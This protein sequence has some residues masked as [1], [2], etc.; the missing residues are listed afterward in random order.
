MDCVSPP[1][2][3]LPRPAQLRLTALRKIDHILP[4]VQTLPAGSTE[5]FGK[6]PD[7]SFVLSRP[8]DGMIHCQVPKHGA[9][10]AAVDDILRFQGSGAR[11]FL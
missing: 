9:T 2:P 10:E 3:F 11:R 4:R 8:A 1:F 5:P 7:Q 6:D